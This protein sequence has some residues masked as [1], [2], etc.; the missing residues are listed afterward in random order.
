[1]NILNI[2]QKK[3]SKQLIV[4]GDIWLLLTSY[5]KMGKEKGFK[6]GSYNQ[7]GSTI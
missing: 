2:V 6:D 4:Q 7:K 5:G 3:I 1:M